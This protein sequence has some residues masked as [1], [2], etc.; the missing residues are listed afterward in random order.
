MITKFGKRFLTTY[1]AGNAEFSNK[2]LALGIANGTDY[3]EADTNSRLGFEFYKLP[4]DF[5]SI[6]I[7]P[8]GDGSYTYTVVYK[9][10]IPQDI[11]G[12]IKEVGLYSNGRKSTN[13]FDSKFL[14]T[15]E[16][17]LDW[18]YPDSTNGVYVN[19]NGS[20][21]GSGNM[22][23]DFLNSTEST[24]ELITKT[25]TI[26]ISGYS[27]NDTLTLA[28][29]RADTNLAKLR[30]KF[31]SSD[32]DYYYGDITPTSGTGDKIQSVSM[33]SVFSNS[34]GSPIS[35]SISKIGIEIFRTSTSSPSVVYLDGLR[36]NDEDTFDATFGMIS[37]SILS[38]PITKVAGRQVD[39]EYR[40]NLGW[41]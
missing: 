12:I 36:I 6:D 30:I 13:N 1:I 5:G 3:V 21:V 29:N 20:R 35:S 31:Y 10:T 33:A 38:S 9:A 18:F 26:D 28:Y 14:S 34:Y 27:A 7:Q 2:T 15:F 11:I 4:V 16:N 23:L 8:V 41:S 39:I 32:T 19:Q 25:S 17:N 40:L 37:R 22:R 24:N